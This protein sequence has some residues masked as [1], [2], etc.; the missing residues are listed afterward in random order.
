[1]QCNPLYSSGG[2]NADNL[3][4]IYDEL[5]DGAL[6]LTHMNPGHACVIY[7][8]AENGEVLLLDSDGTNYRAQD[9]TAYL[10]QMPIWSI[11]L[12]GERAIIVKKPK[13]G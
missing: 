9:Y 4:T 7:G 5:A 12:K 13:E 6:V 8:I 10:R 2:Y 1:M 3:Q 11:A